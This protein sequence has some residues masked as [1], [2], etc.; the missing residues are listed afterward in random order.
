MAVD[1][2]AVNLFQTKL[3]SK[4]NKVSEHD[5]SEITTVEKIERQLGFDSIRPIIGLT[6]SEEMILSED[7]D[8]FEKMYIEELNTYYAKRIK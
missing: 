2:R 1:S 4:R 7:A 5:L 3:S 8:V 6:P